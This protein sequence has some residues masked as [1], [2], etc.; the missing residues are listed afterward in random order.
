[1]GLGG[2]ESPKGTPESKDQKIV[3]VYPW[4]SGKPVSG[5]GNYMGQEWRENES[6]QMYAQAFGVG[7]EGKKWSLIP[8]YND[9]CVFTA[10][11]AS[12]HSNELGIFDLGG[13]VWEWCEDKF[14]PSSDGR[15]LR[16]GSWLDDDKG[17]L[18]SSFRGNG[19]PQTRNYTVGFRVVC[20]VR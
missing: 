13:N 2:V 12:F 5:A 3:G 10:R 19:D 8:D 9:G 11:T 4:G 6:G 20:E 18:L 7:K 17:F 15:V 16:G 14:K 1:M